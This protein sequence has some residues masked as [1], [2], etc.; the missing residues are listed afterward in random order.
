MLEALAKLKPYLQAL[1]GTAFQIGIGVHIGDVVVGT[2][3]QVGKG[4]HHK[5]T[6]AIGDAVNFASRIESEN[7]AA[8]TS[9]LISEAVYQQVK[10]QVTIGK[11]VRVNIKGKSGLYTLYEALGLKDAITAPGL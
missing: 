4:G 11:S 9:F 3:G 1:H 8:G 5:R 7:K 6:T 10:Q 2:I